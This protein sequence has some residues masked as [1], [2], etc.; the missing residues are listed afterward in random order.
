MAV[1]IYPV[2]SETL[3]TYAYVDTKELGDD[4]P[5]IY[6]DYFYFTMS[7]DE[8]VKDRQASIVK[9]GLTLLLLTADDITEDVGS[10]QSQEWRWAVC[11]EYGLFREASKRKP[12]HVYGGPSVPLAKKSDIVGFECFQRTTFDNEPVY[13]GR[14]TWDAVRAMCDPMYGKREG[15]G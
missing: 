1:T 6:F 13:D 3:Y 9:H 7:W 10:D 12:G 5:Y 2:V 15:D 11:G 4:A 14:I 8:A